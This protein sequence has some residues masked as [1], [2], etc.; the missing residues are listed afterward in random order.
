MFAGIL[1]RKSLDQQL[2]PQGRRKTVTGEV[3]SGNLKGE[4]CAGPGRAWLQLIMSA[5]RTA[6]RGANP[7]QR[8]PL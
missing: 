5:P 7:L 4:R 2:P 8:L 6:D 3:V 1:L